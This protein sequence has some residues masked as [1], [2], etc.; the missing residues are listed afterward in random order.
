MTAPSSPD[1]VLSPLDFLA[2]DVTGEHVD[3]D[4]PAYLTRC[5]ER[6]PVVAGLD[7]APRGPLCARCARVVARPVDA[8]DTPETPPAGRRLSTSPPSAPGDRPA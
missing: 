2:H 1:W 5:G 7:E 6:I 4:G 3:G 8:A